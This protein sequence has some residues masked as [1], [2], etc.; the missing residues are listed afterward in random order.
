M[1]AIEGIAMRPATAGRGIRVA[2]MIAVLSLMTGFA[3]VQAATIIPDSG[4]LPNVN[5]LAEVTFTLNAPSDVS[6]TTFNVGNPGFFNP[7][8]WLF[9]LGTTPQT[10]LDKNDPAPNTNAAFD[11]QTDTSLLLPAGNYAVVLSAFD[12]HW[13]V[14]NTNC[15]S[16]FYGNTGWSYNGAPGPYHGAAGPDYSFSVTISNGAA[17][18][19][20]GTVTDPNP[21]Q[22]FPSSVP[23]PGSI[24]LLLVGGALLGLKKLRSV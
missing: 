22:A 5:A 9:D 14:A 20:S 3:A 7:T 1:T 2:R 10:Q 11:Y 4:T 24:T 17:L 6:A 8:L 19:T 15:N 18:V 13:C 12:Q 21:T 23:E 16:V